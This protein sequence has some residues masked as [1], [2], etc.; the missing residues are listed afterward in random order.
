MFHSAYIGL[1]ND[2]QLTSRGGSLIA[3]QS[4]SR[5]EDNSEAASKISFTFDNKAP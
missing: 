5:L 2:N 1:N 3:S 4:D